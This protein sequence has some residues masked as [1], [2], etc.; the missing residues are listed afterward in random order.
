M[1]SK[2]RFKA[3]NLDPKMETPNDATLNQRNSSPAKGSKTIMPKNN[4]QNKENQAEEKSKEKG[5]KQ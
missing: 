4:K 1:G 5:A 2:N 3:F